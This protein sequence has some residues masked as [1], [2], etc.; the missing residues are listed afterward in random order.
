M[1]SPNIILSKWTCY[2]YWFKSD[3]ENLILPPNVWCVSFKLRRCWVSI[4]QRWRST[5]MFFST[6]TLFYIFFNSTFYRRR[7]S[8]D[9]Y[10]CCWFTWET[11]SGSRRMNV[12]ILFGK[13]PFSMCRINS[14]NV[15]INNGLLLLL[16][17]LLL[18]KW[19][20]KA[21]TLFQKDGYSEFGGIIWEKE[22]IKIRYVKTDVLFF[23]CFLVV[24]IISW[25]GKKCWRYVE[26]RISSVHINVLIF[27]QFCSDLF[28]S[29][30]RND[31]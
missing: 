25:R 1:N 29:I 28:S 5:K 4:V 2:Y 8:V 15:L 12:I 14:K 23:G 30:F 13:I 6:F 3:K 18:E 24:F 7:V 17:W 9:Y 10:Y 11:R 22:I 16:F 21:V 27:S 26:R 19:K 31:K 20:N